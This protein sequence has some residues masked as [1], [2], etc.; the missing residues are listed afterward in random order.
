MQNLPAW[1]GKHVESDA[2]QLN[3]KF[4]DVPTV[5]PIS[6]DDLSSGE[7]TYMSASVNTAMSYD[8]TI[9]DDFLNSTILNIIDTSEN[10]LSNIV[11]QQHT[12]AQRVRRGSTASIPSTKT[13]TT[14]T[15][16]QLTDDYMAELATSKAE[17]EELRNKLTVI[18]EA[19]KVQQYEFELKAEKQRH[20]L[21]LQMAQ[22]RI[23]MERQA[24]GRQRKLETQVA[25]Q[26]TEME[27]Q[28]QQQR[29]DS[30][31]QAQDQRLE[32]E[33][34]LANQRREYEIQS[35]RQ[36]QQ[37]Q[38]QITN[39]INARLSNRDSQ[40]DTPRNSEIATFM[41]T[42]TR[43][44]QILTDLFNRVVQTQ[45][46]NASFATPQEVQTPM[47]SSQHNQARKGNQNVREPTDELS[48]HQSTGKRS[49]R[50]IADLSTTVQKECECSMS[51]DG[52]SP[53]S[54]SFQS[55]ADVNKRR[56][57]KATPTKNVKHAG[58]EDSQT[59]DESESDHAS[60][61]SSLASVNRTPTHS[62]FHRRQIWSPIHVSPPEYPDDPRHLYHIPMDDIADPLD[63][64]IEE[65]T[66]SKAPHVSPY[67]VTPGVLAE[68]ALTEME[69]IDI[70]E[71]QSTPTEITPKLVHKQAGPHTEMMIAANRLPKGDTNQPLQTKPG[72]VVDTIDPH[73]ECNN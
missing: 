11:G 58:R 16:S 38:E 57:V 19:K 68:E 21:E 53:S 2:K 56:D 27:Q 60:T 69:M 44:M 63:S 7:G 14:T 47:A 71:Q 66:L 49:A 18:E 5:A 29:L 54:N 28:V 70:L 31:K 46:Q 52:K 67:E 37:M 48:L 23:D 33:R 65:D 20:E 62:P 55:P 39:E 40:H 26:K 13:P 35:M 51:D 73:D 50:A 45:P 25:K 34:Q 24:E 72:G 10:P 9:S 8:T 36:Q 64:Q 12:W 30:V 4:I 22:Q 43:Q 42:Q 17:V 32:F 6:L 61:I 3:K 41:E 59:P 15:E 1:Y